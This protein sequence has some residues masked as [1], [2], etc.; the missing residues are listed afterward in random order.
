MI[1]LELK[2][3][4][5]ENEIVDQSSVDPIPVTDGV[6]QEG[7]VSEL[8]ELKSSDQENRKSRP[9][10]EFS[11]AISK[12]TL[13]SRTFIPQTHFA[14]KISES[15]PKTNS[16]SK[17]QYSEQ[18]NTESETLTPEGGSSGLSWSCCNLYSKI[19]H[20]FR[21]GYSREASHGRHEK[22]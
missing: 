22:V 21:I 19:I 15:A 4:V 1:N 10:N 6:T 13:F 8:K 18:G 16:G 5:K 11:A 9:R 7:S 17:K 14:E 12:V 3:D 20:L 2:D